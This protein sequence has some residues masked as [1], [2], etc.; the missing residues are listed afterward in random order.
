MFGLSAVLRSI[1]SH[2]SGV[3]IVLSTLAIYLLFQPLRR[4]IQRL[5]DRRFYRRKY[6]AA[7]IVAAF[8]ATLRQEVDLRQLSEQL[9]AVVLETMQPASISLW[10]C[11][12][13]PGKRAD[14]PSLGTQRNTVL[15]GRESRD[16]LRNGT[17]TI[18]SVGL[19][20]EESHG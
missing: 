16:A 11:P 10:L 5:I 6:D 14:V 4:H 15:E 20:K 3:A 8:N 1:I 13:A 7:K 18:E 19:V 9:V 2:D 17:N 12:S